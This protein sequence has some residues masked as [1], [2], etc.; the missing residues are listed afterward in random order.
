MSWKEFDSGALSVRNGLCHSSTTL[1]PLNDESFQTNPCKHLESATSN[2]T[3]STKHSAPCADFQIPRLWH[4]SPYRPVTRWTMYD[5][6][7]LLLLF[8]ASFEFYSRYPWYL[9]PHLE[10]SQIRNKATLSSR[11][12]LYITNNVIEGLNIVLSVKQPY[13]TYRCRRLQWIQLLK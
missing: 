13:R 11:L 4:T 5:C 3:H 9:L 1:L 12:V 10:R 6:L 2:R 7:P 8:S